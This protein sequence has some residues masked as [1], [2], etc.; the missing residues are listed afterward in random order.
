MNEGALIFQLE[1]LFFFYSSENLPNL[2]LLNLNHNRI[3][4][5]PP[6]IKRWM[7]K[8]A[9][10]PSVM[11]T[12]RLFSSLSNDFIYSLSNLERFSIADNQL[13]EIPAELGLVSKL[14]EMNLSRNKLSE[15]PRELYKL[16]CLR[17][18]SLARNGL[19]LLPEVGF[20]GNSCLE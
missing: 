3:K 19:R 5:I 13:E 18:L 20:W 7:I 8:S 4:I 16:T 11:L 2:I 6:A 9:S 12:S 1:L 10:I 15:I 14:M 17:K